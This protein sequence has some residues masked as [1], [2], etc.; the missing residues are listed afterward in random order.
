[1]K[2][3]YL[4]ESQSKHTAGVIYYKNGKILGIKG[5]KDDGWDIPKGQVDKN[6]KKKETAKR[7]TKE[8]IGH[9]P[10]LKRKIGEYKFHGNR[11]LHLYLSKEIPNIKDLEAQETIKFKG[12][13]YPEKE[14]FKWISINNLNKFKKPLQN[15]LKKA[16]SK[17]K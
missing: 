17:I 1:M 5:I 3:R 16:L 12:K 13:K 9:S 8:E 14:E 4:L 2:L 15:I 6:E 11:I 10:K 7:E